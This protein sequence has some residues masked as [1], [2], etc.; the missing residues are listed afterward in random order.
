M[1]V[2]V[3]QSLLEF[4]KNQRRVEDDVLLRFQFEARMSAYST[5]GW[6]PYRPGFNWEPPWWTPKIYGV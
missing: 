6:K 4:V 3:R 5:S 1:F 2:T